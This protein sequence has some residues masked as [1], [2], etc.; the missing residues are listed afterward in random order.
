MRT[1]IPAAEAE[2]EPLPLMVWRDRITARR[3]DRTP[4][5]HWDRLDRSR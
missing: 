2:A 1:A 5:E 3:E 4:Y